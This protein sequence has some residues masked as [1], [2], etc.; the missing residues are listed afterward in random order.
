MK[1]RFG[2]DLKV[3][4]LIF[5]N[6]RGTDDRIG[7][8]DAITDKKKD[9]YSDELV[10]VINC[11]EIKAAY[12]EESDSDTY[13]AGKAVVPETARIIKITLEQIRDFHPAYKFCEIAEF[14]GDYKR[15]TQTEATEFLRILT[16][17]YTKRNTA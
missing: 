13:Y 9:K 15:I 3:G 10:P 2:N 4:D 5:F 14:N 6:Y 12:D 11:L 1:D 7:I 8:I 16:N 17:E